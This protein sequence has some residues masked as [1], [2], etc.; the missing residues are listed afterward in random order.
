MKLWRTTNEQGIPQSPPP[1]NIT[2]S[3]LVSEAEIQAMTITQRRKFKRVK[4]GWRKK[5]CAYNATPTQP[6]GQ[7]TSAANADRM[8][9]TDQFV[10]DGEDVMEAFNQWVES[11]G[12]GDGY[13]DSD[14]TYRMLR[15][16]FTAGM[17][18]GYETSTYT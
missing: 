15:E 5:L 1:R 13:I 10:Y 11:M 8:G 16:A 9:E 2:L 17:N 14:A 18:A 7:T 6:T 4:G 12:W 3:H